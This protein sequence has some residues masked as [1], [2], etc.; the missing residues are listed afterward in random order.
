MVSALIISVKNNIVKFIFT[1]S[2]K[3]LKIIGFLFQK[4]YAVP[5]P[6]SPRLNIGAQDF[7]TAI[8]PHKTPLFS[9]PASL[10]ARSCYIVAGLPAM[11]R[12]ALQAGGRE[13]LRAGKIAPL[14][15]SG[16]VF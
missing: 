8:F 4:N 1:K 5:V 14:S 12:I 13:A 16:A 2:Y 7:P 9:P 6:P 3:T 10:P 11:L 15:Q